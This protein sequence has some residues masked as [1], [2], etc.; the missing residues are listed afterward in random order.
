MMSIE[1][2]VPS[3]IVGLPFNLLPIDL[4]FIILFSYSFIGEFECK[5]TKYSMIN[6]IKCCDLESLHKISSYSFGNLGK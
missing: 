2:T 3:T 1:Y 5:G 6:G 4:I